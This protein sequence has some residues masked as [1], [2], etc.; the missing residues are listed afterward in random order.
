MSDRTTHDDTLVRELLTALR[1]LGGR[2]RIEDGKLKLRTPSAGLPADLKTRLQA[3]R[4]AIL[5]YLSAGSGIVAPGTGA[6]GRPDAIPR[7]PAGSP[8]ALSYAQ[9]R[10]WFL[11]Q[12]EGEGAATYN[13]VAALSL[14][15]TLDLDALRQTARALVER[16]QS[17]RLRFPMQDG[18][19][20]I[21]D[22]PPYDP[23]TVT[24]LRSLS[25]GERTEQVSRLI[26]THATQPLALTT[27]PLFQ[28][29]LLVLGP[30]D[31]RLLL[32][33]HHIIAD[34]WSMGVLIHDW[35]ELYAA[36]LD[37]RDP[38]SP[39]CP[40]TMPILPPGNEIGCTARRSRTSSITGSKPCATCP[41]R[42]IC[43]RMSRVRPSRI[44]VE[45]T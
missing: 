38:S 36:C 45:R 31:H 43:P 42:S 39:S 7:R 20:W 25:D 10:L 3:N 11:A 24:D 16:H 28:L 34:G 14:T 27:G 9:Q 19:P 40:S 12:L 15:G 6:G 2:I 21:E 5:A 22:M 37:G 4:E 32:C 18:V 17:L 26:R 44:I 13:I 33:M 29:Q 23:L 30:Q 35:S 1:E 8:L 41:N